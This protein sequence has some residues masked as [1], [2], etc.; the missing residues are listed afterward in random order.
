VELVDRL[1]ARRPEDRFENITD[2][3]GALE[4]L[5]GQ[6]PSTHRETDEIPTL[7]L[8]DTRFD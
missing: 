4:L 1:L 2:V 8:A 6:A 7:S 3:A 5:A